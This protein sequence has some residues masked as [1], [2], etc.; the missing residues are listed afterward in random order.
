MRCVSATPLLR[1]SAIYSICII[2]FRLCISALS[3]HC[4]DRFVHAAERIWCAGVSCLCDDTQ[5]C[6]CACCGTFCSCAG[7]SSVMRGTEI[8]PCRN[9]PYAL[10]SI[11]NSE[12]HWLAQIPLFLVFWRL[13]DRIPGIARYISCPCIP[14]T[15]LL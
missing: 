11:E 10:M 5:P 13:Q 9:R 1:K 7:W 3:S 12:F 14:L 2:L 15:I 4:G 8:R 6:W